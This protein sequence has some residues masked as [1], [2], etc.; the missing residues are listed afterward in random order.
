MSAFE[1]ALHHALVFHKGQEYE[2]RGPGWPYILHSI[3]VALRFTGNGFMMAIAVLHDAVEDTS[4][5]VEEITALFGPN[6]SEAIDALSRREGELYSEYMERVIGNPIAARV[7]LAD[8]EEN[9][10]M[11]L[12]DDA[13]ARAASLIPRY[14]R[15]IA[16]LREAGVT[17]ER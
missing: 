10:S 2:R 11:C 12:T 3:R 15:A 8:L 7:K 13:P 9:L 5:T 4:A 16:A 14:A 17:V 6:V 1:D